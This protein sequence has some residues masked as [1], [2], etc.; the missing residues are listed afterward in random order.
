MYSALKPTR[1]ALSSN[2]RAVCGLF[3]L[4]AALGI[5]SGAFAD[6]L[7]LADGVAGTA[8]QEFG[9][10]LAGLE[11]ITGDGLGELLVGAPGMDQGGQDAGAAFLWLG[12]TA[13]TEEPHA[14]WYGLA[15]ENF[16]FS[17]AAIGDVN[18]DDVPDFAVGAP[19]NDT[20]GTDKGRVCIFYGGANLSATPD[21]VIRGENGYDQFGYAIGAAGDF[22]GD[23]K[24]DLI[25]GAPYND[26]AGSDAGA[27]Y[28]IYGASGGPSADLG[29]ALKLTGPVGGG[30]FGFSVCGAGNFLAGNE[31]AVAVGAPYYDSFGLDAGAV[32]VFE[33]ADPPASPNAVHDHVASVGGSPA[34]SLFGWVVRNVGRWDSDGYDDLAVGAPGAG[35]ETG[36]VEIFFGDNSPS[37]QGDRYATGQDADDQL[38]YSLVGGQDWT[39]N[40]RDD[41]LIGAPT[42]SADGADAGRAYIFEGGSTS[43][44]YTVLDA[45]PVDPMVAGNAPGDLY[46]F[47]VA[48][49]TDFDGDGTPD[50]G[51]GAPAGNISFNGTTAG[52]CRFLATD[53]QTVGTAPEG[54]SYA[55][56]QDGTVWVA[57]QWGSSWDE[58]ADLSII[59]SEESA[60]GRVLDRSVVRDGQVPGGTGAVFEV[61]DPGPFYALGTEVVAYRAELR[62]QDG[63]TRL[64]ASPET[65]V[66]TDRPLP[67]VQAGAVWPNPANPQASL[68]FRVPAGQSYLVTV[69]DV[70][71]HEV[72]LVS[73]GSGTGLNETATW[74]GRDA[75]G[76]QLPSGTYFFRLLAGQVTEVRKVVLAR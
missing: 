19:R 74:D 64:L 29:E 25:V 76:R 6:A 50:H 12:N 30:N 67:R 5:A 60:G 66:F 65:L 54:L 26:A 72:A 21:L 15:N 20:G 61:V 68:E 33:G 59:R 31:D 44:G 57:V 37:A 62:L 39:E 3:G 71:G 36:R 48:A 28:I 42:Q 46:G 1:P 2:W 53:P 41:V 17:V 58:V 40:G 63:R 35:G 14:A 75:A 34:G 11:D 16:G 7:H 9:A 43:G 45:L 27:A 8:G 73:Q 10:A 69:H 70:R 13:V 4:L 24:D 23:G 52:Y 56:R 32:F 47:A 55:W 38:G 51:I 18:D 22:N 49:C